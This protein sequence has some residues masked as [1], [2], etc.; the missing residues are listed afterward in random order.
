[1]T[2]RILFVFLLFLLIMGSSSSAQRED[3]V[4]VFGDSA[5][6]DFSSGTA[7]AVSNLHLE[8][9][10]ENCSA[11]SNP[12]G[13]LLYYFGF[14]G[15]NLEYSIKNRAGTIVEDGDSVNTHYS[16][17]NGSLLI[18]KPGSIETYFLYH[19]TGYDS[20]QGPRSLAYTEI[21]ITDDFPQG[22]VIRKNEVIDTGLFGE[23]IT[24]IRHSNGVD[25]WIIA[26]LSDRNEIFIV[27]FNQ[28]GLNNP[29]FEPLGS[30]MGQG[31]C[32]TAGEITPSPS[33]E[34][35]ALTNQ[36]G[37]AEIFSFDRCT[38]D[39]SM[40]VDLR[41]ISDC[42]AFEGFYG[43]SFSPDN[44]F[45]YFSTPTELFQFDLQATNILASKTRIWQHFIFNLGVGQHQ[46]GP[47]GKIY[48]TME[49]GGFPRFLSDTSNQ[50]LSVIHSPNS[51]GLACDFRPWSL[52][53]NGAHS[54]ASLPNFPNFRLGPIFAQPADAGAEARIC[55]RETAQIGSPDTS[56]GKCVFSWWPTDGLDDPSA[57]MPF[58]SPDSTTTYYLTVTD[59][60][61][62]SACNFSEDSVTVTVD[63]CESVVPNVVT[64]NGDGQNDFFQISHLKPGTAVQIYDRWGRCLHETD[65]YQNDWP[66]DRIRAGVYYYVV[67]IPEPERE[68]E[69]GAVSVVR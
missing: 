27:L 59:T 68:V 65:N 57:A 35:I 20:V 32:E 47:D 23:K 39:L 18:P 14:Q 10:Q 12:Q 19:I 58:A 4:W 56:G 52:Y 33:G 69:T 5:G 60:T 21:K 62:N 38:G 61:V 11:I 50:N 46:L 3:F 55:L 40:F 28:D 54:T 2:K 43:V 67:R 1:M 13:N 49:Y 9:F 53:L 26:P 48:I 36:E 44:R 34:M 22:E 8:W 63:L 66:G 16:H 29:S 24:A 37:A 45:V 17:T 42:N 30:F 25:W 51:P 15:T 64:P 7:Q 31:L 41:E 6:L